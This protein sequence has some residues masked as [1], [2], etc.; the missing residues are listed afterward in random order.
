MPPISES[1]M[2]QGDLYYTTGRAVRQKTDKGKRKLLINRPAIRQAMPKGFS[3]WV[4]QSR[5]YF[6]E[7]EQS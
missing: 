4:E 6:V 3:N 5:N 1:E 2:A 7:D